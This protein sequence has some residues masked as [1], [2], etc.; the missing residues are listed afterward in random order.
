[1]NGS[2]GP[3]SI[4]LCSPKNLFGLFQGDGDSFFAALGLLCQQG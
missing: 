4:G 1:M 2:F 3:Y